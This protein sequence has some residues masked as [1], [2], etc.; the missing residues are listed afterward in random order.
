MSMNI[1]IS[2]E[3]SVD[4]FYNI[5][6]VLSGNQANKEAAEKVNGC[7]K[8]L[9]DTLNKK[10]FDTSSRYSNLLK[11]LPNDKIQEGH[12]EVIN[13]LIGEL[14]L[15]YETQKIKLTFDGKNTKKQKTKKNKSKISD[16]N[17]FKFYD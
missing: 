9:I 17:A 4:T 1:I 15:F 10:G 12:I 16:W 2:S 7:I 14:I 6:N 5:L 13:K 8:A 3:T 11:K